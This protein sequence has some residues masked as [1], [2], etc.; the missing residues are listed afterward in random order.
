ML[1]NGRNRKVGEN[2]N[3]NKQIINAEGPLDYITVEEFHRLFPALG[4]KDSQ[5]EK[6]GQRNPAVAPSRGFL[7]GDR[8]GLAVKYSQV[9]EQDAQHKNV[10]YDP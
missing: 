5:A 8:V 2:D 10:E 4:Q 7:Y 9:K 3:Q 1:V 6:E